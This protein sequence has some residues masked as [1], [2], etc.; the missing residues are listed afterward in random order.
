MDD[1]PKQRPFDEHIL[2]AFLFVVSEVSTGRRFPSLAVFLE[3]A[4]AIADH[5]T[6]ILAS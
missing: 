6:A 4:P 3:L 1:V 2:K 5:S